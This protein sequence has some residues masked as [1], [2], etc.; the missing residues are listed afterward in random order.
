MPRVWQARPLG[1]DE[2]APCQRCGKDVLL[3]AD[4]PC[5]HGYV[6]CPECGWEAVCADCR[7]AAELEMYASGEYN[8]RADPSI[9][10]TA[11]P[12]VDRIARDGGYWWEGAWVS[13]PRKE[14]SDG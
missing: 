7:K 4:P 1:D 9:D 12:P 5:P 10:H 8:P 13:V 11:P 6:G 14:A 2:L 3:G